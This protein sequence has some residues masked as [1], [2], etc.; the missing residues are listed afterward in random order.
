MQALQ[1]Q[2]FQP[3]GARGLL[4]GSPAPRRAQL[5]A[6]CLLTCQGRK[7]DV[8]EPLAAAEKQQVARVFHNPAGVAGWRDSPA[9]LGAALFSCCQLLTDSLPSQCSCCG[10]REFPNLNCN[11]P[12]SLLPCPLPCSAD[13]E[14]RQWGQGE[15]GFRGRKAA[16]YFEKYWSPLAVFE[17]SGK[18]GCS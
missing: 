5:M 18:Q 8:S 10:G 14:S 13:Q 15:V 4:H 1:R 12:T 11:L 9:G 7:Q 16:P 17:G 3:E 2:A 6:V